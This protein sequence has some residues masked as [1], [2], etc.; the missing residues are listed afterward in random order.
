MAE[1]GSIEQLLPLLLLCCMIPLFMNMGRTG[2]T[3]GASTTDMDVWFTELTAQQSFDTIIK[4]TDKFREKVEKEAEIKKSKSRFSFLSRKP[5]QRYVVKEMV[6]PNIY[7]LLDQEEGPLYFE[8]SNAEEG[9]TQIKAA[10]SDKNKEAI[11]GIKAK[12]PSRKLMVARNTKFACPSCGKT[13]L[14]EWKICPHCG[15]QFS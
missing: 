15:S 4:E 6:T 7:R 5:K 11:Q 1:F 8:I 3:P 10:F 14:P 12:M 2:G 9:G 13:R